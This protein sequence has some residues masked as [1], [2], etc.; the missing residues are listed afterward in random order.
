MATTETSY[1]R[2]KIRVLLLENISD[3]AV[4]ELKAGGYTHIEK[5]GGAMSEDDLIRA[6]K[7][8]HL[9]GIRSKTQITKNVVEA[10]DKLLAIGVFASASTRST[11]RPRLRKASLC[12]MHRIRTRGRLRS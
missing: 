5:I 10:A 6:V 9:I 3:T 11:S 2:S 4:A 1:P 7:G 8:V 12:L